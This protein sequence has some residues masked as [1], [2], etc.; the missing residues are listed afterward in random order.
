[1]TNGVP[2]NRGVPICSKVQ[3]HM[4]MRKMDYHSKGVPIFKGKFY[5]E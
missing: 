5:T 1:M 4:A 2:I 3:Y